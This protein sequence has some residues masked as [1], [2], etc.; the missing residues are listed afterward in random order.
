MTARFKARDGRWVA[1]ES[2]GTPI[3]DADG[4]VT[5][6]LGTARDVSEREELRRRVEE[7]DAL[8]RIADVIAR[9]GSLDELFGEAVETLI[10]TTAADRASVLLSDE[11]GVMRF[12]AWSGLSDA[13]RA[14]AEGHSP[15]PPNALDPQPV[16]GR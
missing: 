5:H 7:L 8:Y 15:W 11:E 12:T 3:L 16:L 13:Y 1:L 4:T 14:A 10:A 2:S 6:L 9:A